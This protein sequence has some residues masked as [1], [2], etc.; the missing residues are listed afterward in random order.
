MTYIDD[1]ITSRDNY[2]ALLAAGTH[3]TQTTYSVDGRSFDW[4]GYRKH[5]LE[6]IKECQIQIVLGSGQGEYRT[7]AIG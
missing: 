5:L 3:D 4:L 1:L 2:A 7:Q 6:Q